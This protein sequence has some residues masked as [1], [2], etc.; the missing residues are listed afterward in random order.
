M[1]FFCAFFK[2]LLTVNLFYSLCIYDLLCVA[3]LATYPKWF[4]MSMVFLVTSSSSSSFPLGLSLFRGC[5]SK[6]LL[7]ML[8]CLTCIFHSDTSYLHVLSHCI[9]KSRLW[10]P[11]CLLSGR[12]ISS[13]LIPMYPVSVLC[14][15]P[16]YLNPASLAFSVIR[17]T[18][19]ALGFTLDAL[20]DA[21]LTIH[22]GLGPALLNTNLCSLGAGLF[23]LVKER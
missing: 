14:T 11:L 13:I 15:C 4:L 22:P 16:N 1:I 21:T 20:P 9:H 5:H 8:T 3:T 6:S 7:S 2:R 18:D 10:L 19:L 12:Y 23:F 17:N